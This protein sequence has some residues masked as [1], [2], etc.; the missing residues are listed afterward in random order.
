LG[1]D[2]LAIIDNTTVR[3]CV[4]INRTIASGQTIVGNNCLFNDS[5]Y[6]FDCHIGDNAIIVN[7]VTL[8]GHVIVADAIIGGWQPFINLF[9]LENMLWFLVVHWLEKMFL[10]HKA[11]KNLYLMLELTHRIKK[12]WIYN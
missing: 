3:E 2:S 1:E 11:A 8:A 7:G 10:A 9:I 12:T 4:T 5:T 6:Y